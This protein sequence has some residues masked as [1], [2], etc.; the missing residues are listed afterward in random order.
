MQLHRG[1]GRS[2]LVGVERDSREVA[3]LIQLSAVSFQLSVKTNIGFAE[4]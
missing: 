1:A 2:A 3:A 4:S